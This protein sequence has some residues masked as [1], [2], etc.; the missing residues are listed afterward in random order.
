MP[1][2]PSA[3]SGADR[4]KTVMTS[5]DPDRS[6]KRFRTARALHLGHD[7]IGQEE[8]EFLAFEQRHRLGAAA[9]RLDI[10]ADAGEGALEILAHRSIVFGQEDLD[11]PLLLCPQR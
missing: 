4:A 7:D 5:A 9:D 8:V 3:R 1:P 6:P 11:H 10:V 2:A